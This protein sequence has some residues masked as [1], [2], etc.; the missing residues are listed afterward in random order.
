MKDLHETDPKFMERYEHFALEEVVNEEVELFSRSSHRIILT[1]DGML[2]KRRAQ[3]M[4]S[5]AEKTKRVFIRDENQL[6]CEI[7]IGCGEF[8]SVSCFSER[9]AS[10]HETYPQVRYE[11]CRGHLARVPLLVSK[12]EMVQR[13]NTP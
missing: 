3:E 1:E 10:F 5:L 9:I 11:L 8:G 2:L 12:R 4:I 13:G 7:S 6:T